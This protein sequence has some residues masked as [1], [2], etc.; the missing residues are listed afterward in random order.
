MVTPLKTQKVWT[1]AISGRVRV[2][3]AV[4]VPVMRKLLEAG[5]AEVPATK[6]S[7]KGRGAEPRLTVPAAPGSRVVL[8]ATEVRLDKAALAPPLPDPAQVPNDSRPEPLVVR[9]LPPRPSALG[10]VKVRL[11][12][13]AP[14][15]RVRVLALVEFLNATPPVWELAVP[16]VREP[17]DGMVTP[18]PACPRIIAEALVPPI[19]ICPV[20]PVAV[21][22]SIVTLPELEVVPVALPL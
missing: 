16:R 17:D 13:V 12:A 4:A 14:L 5:V 11:L 19:K 21:P 20:A 10:R 3:E 1:P 7:P 6:M 22:E 9:Q 15:W 2:R 8:M 18:R